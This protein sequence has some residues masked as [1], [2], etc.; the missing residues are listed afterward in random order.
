LFY[1]YEVGLPAAIRRWQPD[2][3]FS[4][5]NYLPLRDLRCPT[6]LLEQHAGHFSQEYSAL[7]R[8]HTKSALQRMMWNYKTAWVRRSVRRA[9]TLLVQTQSLADGI[10]A[11]GL[12]N[13]DRIVVVPHGPGQVSH[14]AERPARSDKDVWRIGYLTK[15]G[16][17]KDFETFFRAAQKIAS[18]GWRIKLVL[19]LDPTHEP[20]A[21]VLHQA[22]RLGV[23]QLIENHGEVRRDQIGQ[24][25]DSLDVMVF[26]S[27]C[28]SFGFPMVEAMA[29]GV[30]IVVADTTENREITAAAGLPFPPH[31]HAVLTQQLLRIMT[32]GS[33]V[34]KCTERSLT[35]GREFSW[36]SACKE[37]LA[38]LGA[39]AG[40]LP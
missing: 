20:A 4:M 26:C 25:Y 5:T 9:G 29:R 30:P 37:T 17:Q 13:R 23:S 31:D 10:A 39:A 32:S 14:A 12:R 27:I 24:L 33:E 15:F 28:E 38:V 8:A 40:T 11:T 16:V 18:A 6:V 2:V 21:Q 35:R 3:L 7:N 1:W 34:Q 19:T 36:A 22:E